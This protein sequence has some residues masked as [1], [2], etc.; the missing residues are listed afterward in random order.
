M[1]PKHDFPEKTLCIISMG[2]LQN[3][4][5]PTLIKHE[6]IIRENQMLK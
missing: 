2:Q 5:K 4:A 1:L 6:V 3:K